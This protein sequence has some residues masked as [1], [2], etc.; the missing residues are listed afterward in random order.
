MITISII[1]IA[2]DKSEDPDKKENDEENEDEEE[3]IDM[4]FP[5][6]GGWQK[7]VL[8]LVSFPIMAPLYVTLP[9]TKDKS[10]KW[11]LLF[12]ARHHINTFYEW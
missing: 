7:I 9:D 4:S 11:L 5:L 10:S 6:K 8:Y 12:I 1:S 2:A 3:P